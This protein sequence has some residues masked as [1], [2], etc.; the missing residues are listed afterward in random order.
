[1]QQAAQ[2]PGG[3]ESQVGYFVRT[4]FSQMPAERREVI[5]LANQELNKIGAENRAQ[6]VQQYQVRFLDR[7]GVVLQEGMQRNQLRQID[8]NLAVWSL[9]GLM[10]PFFTPGHAVSQEGQERVVK[11]ILEIYF[12]GMKPRD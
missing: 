12:E 10:Y 5:R 3:V 6:F 8:L 7:L 1:M 9:L 11:S 2:Q 4:I